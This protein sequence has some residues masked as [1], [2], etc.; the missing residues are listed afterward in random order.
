MKKKR[1]NVDHRTVPHDGM[2]A[3]SLLMSWRDVGGRRVSL[4]QASH[5]DDEFIIKGMAG[6]LD[7]SGLRPAARGLVL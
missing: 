4:S 1:R 5:Q 3:P 2:N 7:A 6:Q